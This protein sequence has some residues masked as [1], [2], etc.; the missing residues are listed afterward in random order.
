MTSSED[1][2]EIRI[3]R[4]LQSGRGLREPEVDRECRE[5]LSTLNSRLGMPTRWKLRRV[6]AHQDRGVEVV[7]GHDRFSSRRLQS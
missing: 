5:T 3:R 4:P 1:T 7:H 6:C 2:I